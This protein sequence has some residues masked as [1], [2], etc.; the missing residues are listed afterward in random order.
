M[1]AAAIAPGSR[2]L[3]NAV[4][5][6]PR[7]GLVPARLLAMKRADEAKNR[8]WPASKSILDAP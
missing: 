3:V 7:Q 5:P 8:G 6:R 1:D 4:R 2:A